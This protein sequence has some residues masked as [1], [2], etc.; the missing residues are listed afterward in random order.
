MNW[1]TAVVIGLG[2]LQLVVAQVITDGAALGIPVLWLRVLGIV[3]MALVYVANQ[4]KAIGA[5]P[6]ASRP[7]RGGNGTI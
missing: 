4:L 6:P 2:L 5:A 3:S 7:R 1:Q